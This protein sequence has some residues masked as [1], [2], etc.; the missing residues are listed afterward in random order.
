M[1]HSPSLEAIRF[2]ASQ[3]IPCILWNPKVH[4]RIQKRPSPVPILSQIHPLHAP[5]SHVLKIHLNIIRPSISGSSKWSLSL[6]VPHQT[7]YTPDL[8][9]TRATLTKQATVML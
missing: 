9:P 6:R 5:E 2:P 7:L 3:Q 1:E 8:S 4:N